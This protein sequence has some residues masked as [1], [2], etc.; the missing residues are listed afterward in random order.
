MPIRS[1]RLGYR[2]LAKIKQAKMIDFV[3]ERGEIISNSFQDAIR[4]KS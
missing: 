3:D 1:L 4:R 2:F